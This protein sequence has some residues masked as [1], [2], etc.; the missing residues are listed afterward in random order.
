MVVMPTQWGN[1]NTKFLGGDNAPK[2]SP[3]KGNANHQISW[4]TPTT[5]N[6]GGFGGSPVV[7]SPFAF[8]GLQ[9][10]G[11]SPQFGWCPPPPPKLPS[12]SVW[13]EP[14]VQ[15]TQGGRGGG[16]P[17]WVCR[18]EGGCG[19]GENKS[20]W[21]FCGRCHEPW[22]FSLRGSGQDLV[23]GKK[24]KKKKSK[25]KGA[26]GAGD[27]GQAWQYHSKTSGGGAVSAAAHGMHA[28]VSGPL[29]FTD[30]GSETDDVDVDAKGPME[31]DASVSVSA[32]MDKNQAKQHLSKLREHE[33]ALS[34][35][36][37]P[38]NPAV[39]T[40]RQQIQALQDAMPIPLPEQFRRKEQ[41]IKQL[42]FRLEKSIKN[43]DRTRAALEKANVEFE[44]AQRRVAKLHTE[45]NVAEKDRAEIA[46]QMAPPDPHGAHEMGH[47]GEGGSMEVSTQGF[48]KQFCGISDEL[49]QA[50]LD[51]VRVSLEEFVVS[52]KQAIA[53]S[54]TVPPNHPSVVPTVHGVPSGGAGVQDA[55]GGLSA[56]AVGGV[57]AAAAVAVSGARERDTGIPLP[58]EKKLKVGDN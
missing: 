21:K 35:S 30:N 15:R 31:V 41:A 37:G 18:G 28:K 4:G 42:Q 51:K 32:P 56:A 7:F 47:N 25:S 13:G 2:A 8:P 57:P 40:L 16:Q 48:V 39:Q 27:D 45:K 6:C 26:S 12:G 50:L 3:F 53:A 29:F 49:P 58:N 52:A 10:G 34:Q 55:D 54:V 43:L 11:I 20:H 38:S 46:R 22:D 17:F 44:E 19:Y 23:K 1:S 24:G 9:A 5:T 14:H 36:L 33:A